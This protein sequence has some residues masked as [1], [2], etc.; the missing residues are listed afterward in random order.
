MRK[1]TFINSKGEA[2][3]MDY[4]P[5]VIT[6]IHGIGEVQADTQLVSSPFL[7]GAIHI[8]SLLEPRPIAVE[9]AIN[10]LDP[11]K[12][13]EHRSLIQRVCNPKLG[14]GKIIYENES[15]IKEISAIPDGSPIFPDKEREPYQRFLINYICPDPYW[16]DPERVSRALKAYN[17]KFSIPTTFPIELGVSGDSTILQNAGHVSTPVTIE[18]QGPVVNPQVKNLTTGQVFRINKSIS[19]NEVIHIDTTS[20]EKRVEVI[21]NGVS[22]INAMGWVDYAVTDF[23]QL[24]PGD[25]EI[26]YTADAGEHDATV[27]VSWHNRYTGI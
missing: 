19:V 27:A 11:I 6:K 18:I 22:L 17:G 21:R 26:E 2:I 16:R 3:H 7:D 25:N 4:S 13:N 10:I 14:V 20:K 5:I 1:K 23:W 15:G 24:V 9:G 8:D 12:I